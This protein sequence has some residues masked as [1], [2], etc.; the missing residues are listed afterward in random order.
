MS[1]WGIYISIYLYVDVPCGTNVRTRALMIFFI[2]YVEVDIFR[3]RAALICVLDNVV[4]RYYSPRW[5]TLC[6]SK[7]KSMFSRCASSTDCFSKWLTQR[8]SRIYS[9]YTSSVTIIVGRVVY[10]PIVAFTFVRIGWFMQSFS[11]A[12]DIWCQKALHFPRATLHMEVSRVCT[13][14]LYYFLMLF[15]NM[16]I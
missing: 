11:D 9:L 7:I 12:P 13:V 15:R 14:F 5:L 3:E 2:D 16:R 6:V 8:R 10:R 4:C 1:P